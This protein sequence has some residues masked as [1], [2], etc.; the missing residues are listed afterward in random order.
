[1]KN[2]L[3]YT[4]AICTA[5]LLPVACTSNFDEYNTNQ[6]QMEMGDVHPLNLLEHILFTGADG[7][8]YRT[9]L[10]N[11]ELIQYTVQMYT[12]N[13]HRYMIRD[14]YNSGTWN[15]LAR[16]A[17]NSDHM[18]EQAVKNG[19]ANSEAI[20]LTMRALFVS[21]WTDIYGDIPFSEA[22]QGR[23]NVLK[24]KFDTQKE[25]YTQL[26]ADLERAN[27]L[28]MRLLMRLQ[29]R[30][31]EMGVSEKLREI[32]SNPSRYPVMVSNAD[33]A[34]LFYTNVDPFIGHFGTTTLQS[35]TSNSHRMAEHLVNLMNNTNDPRLGIYAVQQNNEWTG[36][37]SGYPTT[38][39][40]ATNCAYL[41]K[42]VLGD[43]TSPYTFMRYDEVLFILSEAAFRGMIPGGSAAAQ[44]YYEQAVLASIDY[45]DEINPS[46]TYEITQAQK[47]AF[48]Q[49]VAF[50][51]TLEQIL[52]QKYIALFWEGYEAWHEYRRT[53]YPN[54][55]IG[56][57]TA[58]DGVLPTR[59]IYPVTTVDT[60]H[61]NYL[62][63]IANQGPDNMK[64]RLWWARKQ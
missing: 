2:I 20:A 22:F 44:Q 17:A 26:F 60:N 28:H 9:W 36:L 32:V 4:L 10:L 54:F 56:K 18:I 27:S 64:T 14:S 59:F 55:K 12:E 61:E 1:M 24:P 8:V 52:N 41:N 46:P 37:V 63:A 58:N 38:E 62:K 16:W 21:N 19:D 7:M 48:M 47:N 25:V 57:G 30:D 43:Y 13:V 6:N 53:G 29:N 40:N 23:N 51:N 33:N 34:A 5:G 11:N 3:R 35:F 39:T 42:D 50:D 31:E 45:W 15:H 49:I